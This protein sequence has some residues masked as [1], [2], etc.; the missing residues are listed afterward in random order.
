MATDKKK[1]KRVAT[2]FGKQKVTT[3]PEIAAMIKSGEIHPDTHTIKDGK[4]APKRRALVGGLGIIPSAGKLGITAGTIKTSPLPTTGTIKTSSILSDSIKS[5]P[6]N[7]IDK[8]KS[9]TV[10]T[11]NKPGFKAKSSPG[12]NSYDP[13]VGYFKTGKGQNAAD[14]ID[15]K[16]GVPKSDKVAASPVPKTDKV[17]GQP[18]TPSQSTQMAEQKALKIAPYKQDL[19]EIGNTIQTLMKGLEEGD[20]DEQSLAVIKKTIEKYKSLSAE[21]E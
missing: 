5:S 12:D 3:T 1:A 11:A 6:L 13:S 14:V 15:K 8:V 4:F 2:L 20:H 17:T 18:I 10:N 9:S 7:T 16:I 21:A 19:A